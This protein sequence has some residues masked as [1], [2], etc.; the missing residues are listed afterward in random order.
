MWRTCGSQVVHDH[1]SSR[2]VSQKTPTVRSAGPQWTRGLADQAAGDGQRALAVAD[3]ADDARVGEVDL[4]RGGR[5]AGR[6]RRPRATCVLEL[7]AVAWVSSGGVPPD[8]ADAGVQ[9]RAVAGDGP[10]LPQLGGRA[11]R[12]GA[13]RGGVGH[14]VAAAG[15]ARPSVGLVEVVAE[16]VERLGEALVLLLDVGLAAALL[17]PP[18]ADREDRAHQ[19]DHGHAAVRITIDHDDRPAAAARRRSPC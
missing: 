6:R 13:C 5:D 9:A 19:R 18:G 17:L 12:R 2:P 1:A 8:V 15:A 7:V 3:D 4:D 16:A 11:A 10:A 14:L